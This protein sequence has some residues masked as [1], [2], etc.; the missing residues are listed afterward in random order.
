[1]SGCSYSCLVYPQR[2]HS[3]FRPSRSQLAEVVRTLVA[4]GWVDARG[5]GWRGVVVD[6]AGGFVKVPLQA[7]TLESGLDHLLSVAGTFSMEFRN[8][9]DCGDPTPFEE[10]GE[11]IF[12][13]EYC[14]DA[15]VLISDVPL[16]VGDPYGTSDVLCPKCGVNMLLAR[17]DHEQ[18]A[19][20]KAVFLPARYAPP[21]CPACSAAIDVESL[22]MSL[23]GVIDG[24]SPRTE[25]APFF[26]FGIW[27]LP[28]EKRYPDKEEVVLDPGLLDVLKDRCGLPFRSV[29]TLECS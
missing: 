28:V 13:P 10:D 11:G 6:D 25:V 2:G 5:S 15:Y 14:E 8:G 12:R 26:H 27:L 7:D 4:A 20:A 21:F 24:P 23:T 19:V 16:V 3:A 18:R 29:G 1:M 22:S 9:R 17:R